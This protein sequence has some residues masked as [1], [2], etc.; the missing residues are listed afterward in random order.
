MSATTAHYHVI[1]AGTDLPGLI[2]GAL[3]AK[4]GYRVAVLGH[5]GHPVVYEHAGHVMC[6][7]VPVFYGLGSPAVRRVFEQ[8]S[9]ALELRNMPRQL[10]PGFQVVLPT[11]RMDM[12]ADE[13]RLRAEFEREMPGET[14][15]IGAFYRRVAEIDARVE[16]V[17]ELGLRLPPQGLRENFQ[18]RRL[19]KRFPFL[20]DEWAIE[21]PLAD[22]GHGHPFRALIQA[23]FR[24]CCDM[25]PARP[26]PATLVRVVDE[27]RKGVYGFESGPDALRNLFLDIIRG[28]GDVRERARIVQI[29]IRRGRASHVVLRDR[30]QTIGCDVLVCNTDP[31]RFFALVPPEQQKDDFHTAIGML[32][33]VYYTFTG[34]FVVNAHAVP[35]AMAHHVFAVNDLRRPLEE[36]NL[37]HIARDAEVG[38]RPLDQPLRTLT[39]SMRVPIS[40][41]VVGQAGVERMLDLLQTRVA[42][43]VPF[44]DEHLVARHSPWL[45]PKNEDGQ[46]AWETDPDELV[47]AFGEALPHTLGTSPVATATGYRN[48]LLGSNAAF[49]G[50][51]SDGPYVAALQMLNQVAELAPMK[52]SY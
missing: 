21:D 5:G 14:G 42:A 46:G 18:F 2:L 12:T 41:T 29:E 38:R 34:S 17:L 47:P 37:I 15:R 19:V 11:G 20:D 16:E 30:R 9:M 22:F 8:L 3:C 6:R 50:F 51:G 39:A 48:V 52:S 49:C 1:I 31:R 40:A 4:R 7:R 35:E 13:Q 27:L 36:D 25:L 43:V 23:P 24:F 10:E 45:R 26:Y 32:Q 33:P 28:G 44:L